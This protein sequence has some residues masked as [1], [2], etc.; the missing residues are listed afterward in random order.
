VQVEL[1]EDGELRYLDARSLID[2]SQYF[3]LPLPVPPRID[4][5]AM[6][7]RLSRAFDL[8]WALAWGEGVPPEG[9]T[10]EF[11][12]DTLRF[13]R[14]ASCRPQVLGEACWVADAEG[15]FT[16]AATV[17]AGVET[18]RVPLSTRY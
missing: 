11:S 14:T 15:V 13:R 2:P 5:I 18:A 10:V 17:V 16:T 3:L 12:S 6:A 9:C 8:P 1:H 4:G 7:T